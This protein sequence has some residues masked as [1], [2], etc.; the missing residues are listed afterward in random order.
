MNA[1]NKKKYTPHP[2]LWI[3][4]V[5]TH[6]TT[7]ANAAP[8]NRSGYSIYHTLLIGLI[9]SVIV[10]TLTQGKTSRKKQVN[11]PLPR[12]PHSEISQEQKERIIQTT[13][14]EIDKH[15]R[16]ASVATVGGF[17]PPDNPCS[18]WFGKITMGTDDEDLPLYNGK[19]LLPLLQVRLDQL[20]YIP[21]ILSEIAFLTVFI[22]PDELPLDN[23]HNGQGFLVR[24]YESLDKLAP[25]ESPQLDSFIKPF[26]I[27]WSLAPDEAPNWDDAWDIVN[28]SEFQ[29]IEGKIDLFYK[30]YHNSD[31]TK[32]G[33][34]PSLIQHELPNIG[35]FVFQIGTEEKARF[36]WGHSGIGYFLLDKQQNWRL[37]WQCY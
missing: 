29:R 11:K 2:L 3:T 25:L 31:R 36:S 27:S 21:P 5:F 19:S 35:D 26:P 34:W 32:F 16:K 22:D 7:I 20:P 4:L 14:Y 6:I 8:G 12:P 9:V 37:T 24:T 17:R 1:K 33:G 23:A 30:R 15:L 28:L 13:F 10:V 18:S